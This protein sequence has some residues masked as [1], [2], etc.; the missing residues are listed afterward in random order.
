MESM[1]GWSPNI[2]G[3]LKKEGVNIDKLCLCCGKGPKSISHSLI[4]CDIV[5][6]VWDCWSDR[7]V[8]ILSIPLDFFD[9]ALEIMTQGTTQDLEFFF[10]TA[11]SI[12]YNRNQV[13]HE[14]AC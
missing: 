4:Y 2:E 11:W 13:V 8:E 6:R 12:W 9:L 1:Y 10:I 14:S 7:P 3:K 5:R